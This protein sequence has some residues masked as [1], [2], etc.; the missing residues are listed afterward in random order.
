MGTQTRKC[1]LTFPVEHL[2]VSVAERHQSFV[3]EPIAQQTLR[4]TTR[5]A[6]EF[7]IIGWELQTN[8]LLTCAWGLWE[9][10]VGVGSW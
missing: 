10:Y 5:Y 2:W 7:R 3:Q 8:N 6:V 1:E 9:P 4:Q